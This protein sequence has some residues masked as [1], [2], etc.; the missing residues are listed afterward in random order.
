MGKT[1]ILIVEDEQD[2]VV[3]LKK[4]LVLEGYRVAHA[5]SA[6]AGLDALRREKPDLVLLDV[7]LPGMNGLEFLK[8]L[9]RETSIPV[10]FLTGRAGE[11]DRVLGLTLGADDYVVKP[12]SLPELVA[13][14]KAILGRSL[15]VR[16]GA[17]TLRVGGLEIDFARHEVRVE[18]RPCPLAPRELQILKLL[19]DAAGRALTRESL[20]EVLWGVDDGAEVST[21]AIDQH[22][23]RLRRKLRGEGPR[24]V[25]VKNA[26]YRIDLR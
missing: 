8:L 16:D 22:V 21:R 25:T 9:R 5:A 26:G 23:A 13:R 18:G 7:S 14:I 24:I 2:L 19:V 6:E 11:L 4:R 12:F 1:G 3:M 10:I 17:G 20:I 15:A